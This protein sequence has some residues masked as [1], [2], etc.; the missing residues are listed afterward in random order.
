MCKVK[1]TRECGPRHL[2]Q[3][4]SDCHG[5]V[6]RLQRIV[7]QSLFIELNNEN[8]EPNPTLNG[9]L[10]SRSKCGECGERLAMRP[11]QS[12][13]DTLGVEPGKFNGTHRTTINKTYVPL[14]ALIV[15]HSFHLRNVMIRHLHDSTEV[16]SLSFP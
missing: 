8:C 15:D 13:C 16:Q 7:T 9:A 3:P 14:T 1:I 5:N 10:S 4:W 12:Q 11:C 2:L 6:L